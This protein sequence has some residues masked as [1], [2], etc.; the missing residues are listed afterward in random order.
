MILVVAYHVAQMC[1]AETE[2]T[3]SSLP[4]L[5]LMRMPLFFFVSGF[6]SYKAS[7]PWT[8][9]AVGHQLWKKFLIQV[10]PTLVFFSVFIIVRMKGSFSEHFMEL[11][12]HSTKGGYWFTWVLLQMYVIYYV[13]LL[14]FPRGRAHDVTVAVLWGVALFAYASLYMPKVVTCYKD[15]FFRYSSLLE[16]FRFMHF[17]LLGNLFHRFWPQVQ[18]LFDSRWLFPLAV[19]MAFVCCAEIFRW[20]TMKFMWT[21]LPR[22]LGMYSLLLIVVMTFR[23][24]GEQFSQS[25]LAGRVLQYIGQRTLD[26]YL[27]HFILMPKLPEAG[28]WLDAHQP[29]FLLDFLCALTV[30]VPVIAA[31]CLVSHVLRVSPLLKKYLFGR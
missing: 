13:V 9:S 14:S 6:L 22:T 17:F 31:C 4:F 7:F 24:Y 15:P 26:I 12:S 1:F 8:A 5:A 21:N 11:M 18:R 28:K 2:K 10:L 20:H 25:H 29:N 3:S 19:L 30:A 27:L 16:T 23:H